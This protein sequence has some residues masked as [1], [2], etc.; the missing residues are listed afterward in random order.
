MTKSELTDTM[1]LHYLIHITYP[2]TIPG[3]NHVTYNHSK[4]GLLIDYR[5]QHMAHQ[6]AN[7][8]ARLANGSLLHLVLSPAF[9]HSDIFHA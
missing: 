7:P 6:K 1:Y 8:A 5:T 9:V 2:G 4:T 3:L